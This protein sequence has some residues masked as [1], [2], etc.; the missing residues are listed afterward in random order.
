MYSSNN[1]NHEDVSG[2]GVLVY[3]KSWTSLAA[4]IFAINS[5]DLGKYR[6]KL[7]FYL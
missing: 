6:M 3:S 2:S 7:S 5:S 4:S 1:C